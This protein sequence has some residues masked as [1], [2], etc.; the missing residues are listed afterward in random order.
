M[1][2]LVVGNNPATHYTAQ[3][4][5]G[6]KNV[7]KVYHCMASTYLK[8]SDKHIPIFIE[9]MSQ[10]QLLSA[11]DIPGIDLIIPT[12]LSLQLW[13][14]YQEKLKQKGIPYLTPSAKLSNL[15]FSKILGKKL[16]INAGVP[17]ADYKVYTKKELFNNFLKIPRPFV[18]K[19]D[20]DIRYGRQTIIVTDSNYQE[21]YEALL[22]FGGTRTLQLHGPFVDQKFVVEEFVE[23]L[24]EYSYHALVNEIS[25]TYIGSAR[26]YKR[27]RDGDIGNNTGGMGSYNTNDIDPIVHS[28][29]DKI[30][31]EIKKG[32]DCY[33]GF[34]YLGVLVK[35][36]GTPIVLEINTRFGDPEIQTIFSVIKNDISRLLYTAATN[37]Q[38]STVEF[39]DKSAVSVKLGNKNFYDFP[40]I[41]HKFTDAIKVPQLTHCPDNITISYEG[42]E[43]LSCYAILTTVADSVES[44][45]D[46]IYNYLK[47]VDIG[48]YTYRTD[49]GYLK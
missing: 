25:W 16:L 36:D 23:G 34:L 19:Y 31:K 32:G 41:K 10:S 9:K 48:E 33:K 20:S 3:L 21:E 30:I 14:A 7:N 37:Q 43:L 28:Y 29:V 27:Y 4:L 45:S 15:E 40:N 44:A 5:I 11:I 24:R 2:I 8:E 1:N 47:T 12:M 22:E 46:T 6:N 13:P 26:D 17:T 42:M 38:L 49:I 18:L 35:K 39:T